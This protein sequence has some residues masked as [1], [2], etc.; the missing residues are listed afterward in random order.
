MPKA[1]SENQ[2]ADYEREGYLAPVPVMSEAAA[3]A[4]RTELETIEAGT[5]GPLRGNLRHKAHLLFPFLADL[6]RHTAILDA[7]EDVLGPDILC[8]NTNFFIKEADTPSFVS[9]HQDSTYWGLSEPDVCTAWVAITP[10][11]LANGAMA[12]IPKSHTMDQIPHRG[13]FNRHNLLTRGQEIA[14]EVDESEA[15]PLVLRPGEMS[16]HHVRLVHGSPPNP[17]PDRRIGFAIRYIPTR[18]RQLEGEDSASLVRGTDRYHH[19]ELEPRPERN[20]P[21]EMLALHRRLTQKAAQILYRGTGV[22]NFND[23]RAVRG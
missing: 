5:G 12:V 17:S 9:W 1:L 15:V 22:D 6:I 21:D 20:M 8:W 23:P 16:L 19:F 7:I 4:V 3:R 11:N 13:T 10:S 2:I 18:V 14:V